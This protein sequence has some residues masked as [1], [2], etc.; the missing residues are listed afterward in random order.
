MARGALPV[1]HAQAAL[2]AALYDERPAGTLARQGAWLVGLG[3]AYGTAA[4]VAAR[5][6]LG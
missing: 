6:M 2:S 4:R 3:L 5:R 1:R